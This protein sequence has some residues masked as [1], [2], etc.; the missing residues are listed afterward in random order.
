MLT[1]RAKTLIERGKGERFRVKIAIV[2]A[3]RDSRTSQDNLGCPSF[4]RLQWDDH[5]PSTL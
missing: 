1:S 4:H 2:A 5:S 3:Q